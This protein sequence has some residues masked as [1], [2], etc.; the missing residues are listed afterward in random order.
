[1]ATKMSAL[2]EDWMTTEVITT[3]SGTSLEDADSLLEE[4]GI[5]R[6]AVV[7][8]G[9]L[10]G[11]LSLG[12]VR[13]AK[14]TA[15]ADMADFAQSPTVGDLMSPDPVTIPRS[16]SIG[17]AAQTMLQLKVTGL[18]VVDDMGQLCGLLSSADLFRFIVKTTN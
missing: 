15:A 8:D 2:V 11:L 1:M 4:R 10:T 7:D 5:R 9:D 14:Y 18:P 3:T 12:D 13:A 17:L 6:L 16:A